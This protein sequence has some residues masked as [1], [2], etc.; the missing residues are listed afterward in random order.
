MVECLHY[1]RLTPS[2]RVCA[3][4]AQRRIATCCDFS[5]VSPLDKFLWA[6]IGLLLT[7]VGTFV[8]VSVPL[9]WNWNLGEVQTLSLEITYQIGAVLL[10]GC[11]GGK[12]AATLSQLAY[13][14][15]GLS[16][17]QI[18]TY[19]GGINYAKEPTFGYLL[20]FIPGAW[21]CG[22]L[23]FQK[24][25]RLEFLALSCLGGLSAIHLMGLLYLSLLMLVH[26]LDQSWGSAALQYS[27]QPLPG[28]LV[29]VCLVT[30][31]SAVLRRLL[32][33]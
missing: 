18:F 22:Y 7:V 19:G 10:V 33:Y 32:F 29:L 24:A 2:N 8:R 16:G 13:L 25:P 27:I 9:P 23:A 17:F 11:L 12:G 1:G 20:G 26:L 4:V 28:Q 15:L 5:L 3:S 31:I 30:V 14:I 21:V 6:V